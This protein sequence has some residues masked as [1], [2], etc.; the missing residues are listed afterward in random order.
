VQLFLLLAPASVAAVS[1]GQ[2][3]KDAKLEIP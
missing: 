2:E 1:D 3:K